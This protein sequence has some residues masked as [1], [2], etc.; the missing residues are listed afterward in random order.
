[1]KFDHFDILDQL[2]AM[3]KE[4]K[5]ITKEEETTIILELQEKEEELIR[6]KKLCEFCKA[7]DSI[8]DERCVA[9]GKHFETLV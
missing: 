7:I 2:D 8:V 4:K 5:G 1:M 6:I 9:C 3:K